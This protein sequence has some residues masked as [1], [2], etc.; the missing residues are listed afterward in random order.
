[1]KLQSA[2]LCTECIFNLLFKHREIKAPLGKASRLRVTSSY[3]CLQYETLG[4]LCV[5][6]QME[7]VGAGVKIFLLKKCSYAILL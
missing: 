3:L 5:V 1:M 7:Q 6:S 2:A 4:H